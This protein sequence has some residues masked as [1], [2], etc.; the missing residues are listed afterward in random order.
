[1]TAQVLPLHDPALWPLRM[2]R[3]EVAHVLRRHPRTLFE[4]GRQ[5][6]FP[7]PDSDHMWARAT[8]QRYAE[9]HI[10]EFD[11]LVAKGKKKATVVSLAPVSDLMPASGR[12]Y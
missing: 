4:L 5:G 6:R 8:V 3:L 11:K 9:G 7:P 2:T 12:R 1:M 10:R